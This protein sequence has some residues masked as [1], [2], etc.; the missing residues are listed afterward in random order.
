[1]VPAPPDMTLFRDD[2]VEQNEAHHAPHIHQDD[3]NGERRDNESRYQGG[4][5]GRVNS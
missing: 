4:Q 1:M 3:S 5:Q 2:A